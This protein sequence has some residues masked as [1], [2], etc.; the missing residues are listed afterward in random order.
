[1]TVRGV[2]T[3]SSPEVAAFHE[4]G[5]QFGIYDPFRNDRIGLARTFASIVLLQMDIPIIN[6]QKLKK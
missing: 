6:Y 4:R 2:V 5:E 1:M 3:Y